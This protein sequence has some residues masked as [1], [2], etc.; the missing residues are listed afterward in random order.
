M[1]LLSLA[2]LMV[3][4]DTIRMVGVIWLPT[5]LL[6]REIDLRSLL[7]SIQFRAWAPAICVL[8]LLIPPLLMY[9]DG[10]VPYNCYSKWLIERALPPQ[11]QVATNGVTPFGLYALRREDISGG[12]VCWPP[13]P[14]RSEPNP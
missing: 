3:A 2:P 1:A 8:Q 6:L 13:R 9:Q 14:I 7:A 4:H 5:Y 10:V 12:I 11:E